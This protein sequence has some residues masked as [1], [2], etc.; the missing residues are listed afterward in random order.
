[1]IKLIDILLE[2]KKITTDQSVIFGVEH[3]NMNNVKQV[4][5][6][7]IKNFSPEDKVVFVGEGGDAN[8][9]YVPG[10]EQE[11]IY[12]KLQDYFNNIENDSW[13][14]EDFDVTNPNAY[15]FKIVKS[16]TGLSKDQ[17][18]AAIY[19]AMVGQDQDPNE[20]KSLLT[21]KGIQWLQKYNIQNPENPNLQD[22]TLMYNLSFPQDTGSETQEI[23]RAIDAY[24]KARDKNLIKKIK[25]YESR[26]YKVI[27]SAGKDHIDLISSL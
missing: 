18:Q 13:D 4:I 11:A 3:N 26:G 9:N 14:G 16:M 2:I 27:A 19:A 12:L 15:V 24:N 1:M 22:K 23:S 6:Y 21:P 8:N 7:V 10:S 25:E 5:N 17:T 20:V